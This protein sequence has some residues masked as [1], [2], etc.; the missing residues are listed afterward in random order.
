MSKQ[1]VIILEGTNKSGK[2]T[3]ADYINDNFPEKNFEMIKCSQPAI[4]DGINTALNEYHSILDTIENNP[5]INFI[6]D[7]FHY[8]SY[9]YGPIY[10]GVEDFGLEKFVDL[11]ER[12]MKLNYIFILAI[13]DKK[14]IKEKFISEKEEFAKLDK[15]DEEIALFKKTAKMSRININLHSIPKKDIT[16]KLINLIEMYD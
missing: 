2:S 8:G 10:R 7:R 11:E 15:I 5:D 6:I 14:F 4:V 16:T 1:L 9:V 3:L 12:I 13:A